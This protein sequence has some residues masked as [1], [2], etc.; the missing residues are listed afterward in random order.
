MENCNYPVSDQLLVQFGQILP[1]LDQVLVQYGKF[2]LFQTKIC[3]NGPT[4]GLKLENCIFPFRTSGFFCRRPK[5]F[6]S[7]VFSQRGHVDLL[8][9]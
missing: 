5:I 9:Q 8:V 2:Y 3:P 6:L 4:P 1:V 7:V